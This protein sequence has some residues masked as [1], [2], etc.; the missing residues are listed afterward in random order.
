MINEYFIAHTASRHTGIY[1]PLRTHCANIKSAHVL[2]TVVVIIL[3]LSYRGRP[4]GPVRHPTAHPA[5]HPT[6]Q[7]VRPVHPSAARNNTAPRARAEESYQCV[8]SPSPVTLTTDEHELPNATISSTARECAWAHSHSERDR[9]PPGFL[10][11][12][13][14]DDGTRHHR[15][16][17]LCTVIAAVPSPE[18]CDRSGKRTLNDHFLVRVSSQKVFFRCFCTRTCDRHL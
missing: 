5:G 10:D 8:I 13:A 9:R 2:P 12:T 1:T 11:G 14:R 16:T 15:R 7:S 4:D 6:A 18:L 17:T 3:L